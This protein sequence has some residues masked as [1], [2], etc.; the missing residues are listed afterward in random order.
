[1]ISPESGSDFF[2]TTWAQK[3]WLPLIFYECFIINALSV[4]KKK[5][6]KYRND[7][8]KNV[9]IDNGFNEVV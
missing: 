8:V 1:M 7:R 4:L 2:H 9:R 5:K 6:L 3:I